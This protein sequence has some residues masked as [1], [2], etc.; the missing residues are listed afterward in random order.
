MAR[1]RKA[2]SYAKKQRSASIYFLLWAAFSAFAL[3]IVLLF[4][5]TQNLLMKQ[6]YKD[7][8]AGSLAANG[9]A[10]QK[11][12]TMY[13]G[14]NY[15]AFVRY[16]ASRYDL[17]VYIVN[18]KG[19]IIF[20]VEEDA[21]GVDPEFSAQ[22]DFPE[23]VSR[24]IE[25]L[26]SAGHTAVLYE[27]SAAGDYVYGAQFTYEGKPI[28][29]DGQPMYLYVCKSLKLIEDVVSQM[30]TRTLLMAIFVLVLSF[31]VSSA[32]SGVLTKPITEMTE[33]A[34]LL[35][36]GDFSVD[37]HGQSYGSE[38]EALAETLNFARDEISKADQMQKEL[39]ANVS[40]DFKTPLTMIK[41]YASMV[42]EISGDNP[43][44]RNKHTQVIIDEADRLTSLVNDVLDL[45]KIRSGIDSLK[46][47]VF[48]LSEYTFDVLE[49]FE[50]LSETKGYAFESDVEE[51]L[52]TEADPIKIGEVL[53]NL[54]GNAVNYTGEN[55]LVRV[56]LRREGDGTIRFAV[57]DT[58]KGI[59]AE[60]ITTIWDR[61]YRSS[62]SHKRPVKGTG[63]G[64]S[65]VKTILEKHNFRF[66]VESVVGK[67][68]TF[69]VIFPSRT[70][71]EREKTGRKV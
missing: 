3:L 13:P 26:D 27:D 56:S 60:E 19:E 49:K 44:K 5:L 9:K 18:P 42:Q 41:A 2:E 10:I 45:S 52:Y 25:R 24:L 29:L 6:S 20:P 37:F 47:E 71:D 70:P 33:K 23:R 55:K 48:D 63:L 39:I 7:Q 46:P 58:G 62:S 64:L 50:Y 21:E 14:P 17:R 61:Y 51:G 66:G 53:Y 59:K 65:I 67:G 8:I 22:T 12:L 69:Y 34:K 68:S 16:Q 31:T 38:M 32:I 4:G 28:Y 11:E 36:K 54:I 43:E 35:A 15:S 40:H 57:A 1:R 30:N